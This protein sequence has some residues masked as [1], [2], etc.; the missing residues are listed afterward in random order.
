MQTTACFVRRCLPS[1]R[2]ALLLFLGLSLPAVVGAEEVTAVLAG[3]GEPAT[4]GGHVSLW[5]NLLNASAGEVS[6]SFR[7]KYDAKLLADGRS[8][9]TTLALRHPSEAG[10]VRI[11]SGGFARRE[12]VLLLPETL[13]GTVVVEVPELSAGRVAIDIR[14]AE[15]ADGVAEGDKSKSSFARLVQESGSTKSKEYSPG[16][17]FK[18]HFFGYEPFYFIAGTE[19]PNA[20]FQISLRYQVVSSEGP[21]AQKFPPLMGLN[22]AYTQTSLWDWNAP[23]APFFDSSYKPE[24]L[25]LWQH[26]DRRRWADWFR[27]DLQGGLQHE[28]NGKAD[29][30]SRSLNIAYLRPTAVFGKEDG[31]QLTLA[32]RVWCYL[33]GLDDNPDLADYRG[34]ADL[35]TIVGWQRG[36]QLSA[37]GHL[38]D[39]R[40]HGSLQLD[41]TYPMMRLLSGSFSLYLYA[42]Y[43]NGY[44]ESLLLY[45][46]RSESFRIGFGLYR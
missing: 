43:F 10:A 25:Y 9:D 13:A 45:N 4:A 24:L 37:T 26:V 21:L 28:S 38:G 44:G 36:L 41:L 39:D 7:P 33:G 35:R 1:C 16:Q 30:D 20:K 12:Y 29:A 31:L 14:P 19:T 8:L 15:K 40:N 5:V 23:S 32:P 3:P 27:L 46:Q 22:A 42:Q 34:Y 2:A 6:G 17:F 11:P 18:E